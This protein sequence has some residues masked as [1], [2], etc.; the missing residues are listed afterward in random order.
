MGFKLVTRDHGE[1][2]RQREQMD[3]AGRRRPEQDLSA[4]RTADA[5]RA[6]RLLQCDTTDR[7]P[8]PVAT[9]IQADLHLSGIRLQPVSP[10]SKGLPM[11]AE[12]LCENE[13]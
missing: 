7:R 2:A 10:L 3:G 4:R 8:R 1:L 11:S 12:G 13:I 9:A 6:V 5:T